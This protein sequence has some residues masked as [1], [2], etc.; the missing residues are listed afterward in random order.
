[1]KNLTKIR[2]NLENILPNHCKK[3]G[4]LKR[5]EYEISDYAS[6]ILINYRLYYDIDKKGYEF[7]FYKPNSFLWEFRYI[8]N[9]IQKLKKRISDL[10]FFMQS[11]VGKILR[12]NK[13][14]TDDDE[15][16]DESSPLSQIIS[17]L[18][19]VGSSLISCES[20]LKWELVENSEISKMKPEPL[21][22]I[23]GAMKVWRLDFRRS[24]PKKIN[25]TN[26]KLGLYLQ[27]IFN[28]FE[29]DANVE[30]AYNNWYK[31]R[32]TDNINEIDA[33]KIE[34]EHP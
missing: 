14:F 33:T 34:R 31:L 21:A 25:I 15:F 27:D 30:R 28:A 12:E 32:R 8:V 16:D 13:D 2:Q 3:Y 29:C 4:F 11:K 24:F 9:D 19:N 10:P 18:D 26:K 6:R 22:I 5:D 7:G 20:A 17:K 1:M 23:E